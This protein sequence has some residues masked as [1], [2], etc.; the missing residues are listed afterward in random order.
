MVNE[1]LGEFLER[2][3]LCDVRMVKLFRHLVPP[4]GVKGIWMP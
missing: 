1:Y 2:V 4:H 3:K